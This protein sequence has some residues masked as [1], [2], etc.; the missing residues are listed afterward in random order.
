MRNGA[1]ISLKKKDMLW[2]RKFPVSN[3]SGRKGMRASGRENN[4]C[5]QN[6]A[7]LYLFMCYEA[8]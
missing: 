7:N 4:L 1:E 5:Q 2:F 3:I 6:A 8:E